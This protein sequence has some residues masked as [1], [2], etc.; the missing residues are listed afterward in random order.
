MDRRSFLVGV[1]ATLLGNGYSESGGTSR[2]WC[3]DKRDPGENSTDNVVL[4]TPNVNL[5]NSDWRSSVIMEPRMTGNNN[6]HSFDSIAGDDF[7]FEYWI[8]RNFPDSIT[9]WQTSAAAA[10]GYCI[11]GMMAEAATGGSFDPIAGTSGATRTDGAGI[12][13]RGANFEAFYQE[14]GSTF[15][16]VTITLGFGWHHVAATYDRSGNM[17]AFLD[18]TSYGT[19]AINANNLDFVDFCAMYCNITGQ[20]AASGKAEAPYMLAGMAAHRGILTDAQI[21]DSAENVTFQTLGSQTFF[22]FLYSSIELRKSEWSSLT[23][24][25]PADQAETTGIFTSST[26][27]ELSTIIADA[28][29]Q[30]VEVTAANTDLDNGGIDGAVQVPD[31]TA[32]SS[33]DTIQPYALITDMNVDSTINSAQDIGVGPGIGNFESDETES[34]FY[35]PAL[36]YDEEWPPMRGTAGTDYA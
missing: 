7:T 29:T 5:G 10:T 17:E 20:A 24:T 15:S 36:G 2:L 18:G 3:R 22:A 33:G 16:A 9:N 14:I 19:A 26:R 4:D 21:L 32:D 34:T 28:R 25:T 13:F 6:T 8:K 27:S 31:K 30:V 35:S 11:S 23:T 12:Q 1:G